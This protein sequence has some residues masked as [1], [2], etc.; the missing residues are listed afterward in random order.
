MDRRVGR[1]PCRPR[2]FHAAATGARR[3]DVLVRGDPGHAERGLLGRGADAGAGGVAAGESTEPRS[4]V[5]PAQRRRPQ[6]GHPRPRPVRGD[7]RVGA[8]APDGGSAVDPHAGQPRHR[9]RVPGR[10][11]LSGPGRERRRC[12]TRRRGTP[13][14]RRRAS[15]ST[16]CSKPASPTTG[17]GPSRRRQAAGWCSA[18]SCGRAPAVINWARQVVASHPHHNV[19]VVTHCLPRGRWSAV[20]EQRWLRREQ[21]GDAVERTRR[22]PQRRDDVLRSRRAGRPTPR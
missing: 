10:Q 6:L 14:T 11:R 17:G 20:D 8:A 4:A 21:P 7:E 22:L 16:G 9:G 13:T 3:H 5:G 15:G 1:L 2:G 18:S 12:A 19:I